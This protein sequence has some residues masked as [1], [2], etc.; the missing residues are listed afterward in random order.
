MIRNRTVLG[1][2]L[3]CFGCFVASGCY[4]TY[5]PSFLQVVHGLSI[6][7]AGYIANMSSITACLCGVSIAWLIRQTGRFRPFGLLAQPIRAAGLLGL[8]PAVARGPGASTAA[9]LV[10]CQFAIAIAGSVLVA[11]NNTAVNAT[12]AREDVAVVIAV[13][14]LFSSI[15]S[16]VGTAVGGVVWSGSMPRL[17]REYL[18]PG[19]KHLALAIYGSLERQ[20]E[21]PE[22]SEERDAIV[23]AYC[24][25]ET[26]LC[27]YAAVSVPFVLGCVLMWRDVP[28]RDEMD[29]RV[30]ADGHLD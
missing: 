19:K 23:K 17:L 14:L 29:G 22:G 20:L 7:S 12:V 4:H 15:G 8:V 16:S 27:V 18:P 9:A 26:R 25:T 11:A 3:V 1:S 21:F 24:V 6:R 10:A 30:E 28:V 2:C 13:L 5:F